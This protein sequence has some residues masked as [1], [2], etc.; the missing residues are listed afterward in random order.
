LQEE[1]RID[2]SEVRAFHCIRPFH[3][4]SAHGTDETERYW[5][6]SWLEVLMG[7]YD[8]LAGRCYFLNR[9]VANGI[10]AQR[11]LR[12]LQHGI[13]FGLNVPRSAVS[14][15]V[16][17]LRTFVMGCSQGAVLKGLHQGGAGIS[18]R[19]AL[20]LTQTL[21]LGDLAQLKEVGECPIFLQ[22]RIDKTYDVRVTVVK[23]ELFACKI[24][25]SRS[26]SGHLDWRVYDLPRTVHELYR[27]PAPVSSS[28]TA[29][30][31][32]EGLDYCAI[33]LARDH[34]GTYWTLDINPFGK[35]LWTEY[36]VGL[37]ITQRLAE[38]LISKAVELPSG[39][40]T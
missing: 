40:Q 39:S 32:A 5:R 2:L 25:A 22:E 6:L 12:L 19:P 27:L 38:L 10:S 11:K 14:N 16:A 28:L 7:C 31:Q 21:D 4:G 17:A 9:A 15:D 26:P 18:D 33:D 34:S 8:Y 13:R 23:C 37:P 3:E 1:R 30:C 35:Y 36:A 29:Y 20:L 24:D